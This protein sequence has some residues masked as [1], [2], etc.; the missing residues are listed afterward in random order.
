MIIYLSI[1]QNVLKLI[2][3]KPTSSSPSCLSRGDSPIV[4]RHISSEMST[5]VKFA[6][7]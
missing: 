5:R 7:F 1:E 3:F 2:F 6:N 4:P